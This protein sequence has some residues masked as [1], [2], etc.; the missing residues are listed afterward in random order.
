M[1]RRTLTAFLKSDEIVFGPMAETFSPTL[2]EVYGG[3]GM[4]FVWFDLEHLG[5]SP[6]DSTRL[7]NLTRAAELAG[8]EL[9]VRLPAPEPAM[10]R[11]VLDTGVR[12]VLVPQIETADEVRRVT[13]AA[14]FAYE[15][16]S[17]ERGL[18]GVRANRWAG[19]MDGYLEREDERTMVGIMCETKTAVENIDGILSVPELGFVFVGPWDLS[20]SLGHPLEETHPDVRESIEATEDA[21]RSADVPVMGFVNTP[22]QVRQKAE[23]GYQIQVIGNEIAMLRS[24]FDDLLSDLDSARQDL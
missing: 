10:V 8:V 19:D 7:E 12:N 1:S 2:V 15:G 21:C 3:L 13:E 14:R 17:G 24:G 9:V 5:P 20:H 16:K 18:G 22:E 6:Y 23:R 11:K 4:D